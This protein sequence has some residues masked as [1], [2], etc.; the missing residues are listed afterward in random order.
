MCTRRCSGPLGTGAG[1]EIGG[2]RPAGSSSKVD[3][4]QCDPGEG[5]DA[6]LKRA[7]LQENLLGPFAEPRRFHQMVIA[8]YREQDE[9]HRERE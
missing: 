7:I 6:D 3:G 8:E 9:G 2:T 4:A 5:E 1:Q